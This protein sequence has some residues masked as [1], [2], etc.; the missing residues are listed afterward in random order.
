MLFTFGNYTVDIDVEKTRETY[1]KLPSVGQACGCDGCVNFEKA[2]D[3]LS[4]EVRSFFDV[5]GVDLKRIVE[6]YVNCQ[7]ADGALFYGGFCNLCGRLVDGESA[8]VKDSET[9]GIYDHGRAYYI[10]GDFCVSFQEECHL[11]EKAFEAPI[12]QMDFMATIP[13]VLD[14]ENTYPKCI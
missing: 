14:R 4:A 6:C 5:L 8:W 13:W 10:H 3:V 12:I 2:V 11:I 7:T 9:S 1:R